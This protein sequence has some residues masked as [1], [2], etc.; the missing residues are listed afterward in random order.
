MVMKEFLSPA[1]LF[2]AQTICIHEPAKVFVVGEYENL[3]I[4]AF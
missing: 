2:G 1:D 4:A 3:I